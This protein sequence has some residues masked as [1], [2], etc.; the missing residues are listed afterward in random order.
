MS[1]KQQTLNM[2]ANE[3]ADSKSSGM[4]IPDGTIPEEFMPKGAPGN[5]A[6]SNAK[7]MEDLPS[8][9]A[10]I[11][12]EVRAIMPDFDKWRNVFFQ[13]D[14]FFVL[15]AVLLECLL[16]IFLY[17]NNQ[18][19]EP[20]FTYILTNI[21]T[22][23]ILN[24]GILLIAFFIKKRMAPYD[25]RQNYIPIFA[26]LL[27]NIVISVTHYTF[28][29]TLSLFCIP[30]FMT[31]IF[32]AK[33]PCRF[34]TCA[35]IGG[36]LLSTARHF[37]ALSGPVERIEIIPETILIICILII[38]DIVSHTLLGMTEGQKNKLINYA[39]TIGEAHQRA[40]SANVAKSAFLANMS[41][42][43]RTPINAILG[44]NEMILRESDNDQITEYAKNIYSA[45]TSLLYL[46]N[47]VLD[48]S[49]IESG[50]LEIVEA[51]YEISS[52]IH[53]CYNMI[54]EKAAEKNLQLIINCSPQ[55]PSQL[56]GDEVR[57]RQV[58][59]NLLSNAAKYTQEGSVTLSVD[60]RQ[61]KDRFLL[62]VTVKDTGIGIK[63]DNLK[64]LFSQFARFDLEKNRNIEGT[65]LGLAITKQL[66]DL[67][68]GEIH[69]ESTYGSG[70]SFTIIVPQQ[71]IESK[72]MGD[73]FKRY[74]DVSL[75]D[76]KY[77]QSFEAPDARVLVVD[78]VEVNLKVIFNLL[79]KT[80][81]KVDTAL[82]GKQCL[83]LTAENKYDLILLDHMMPEM[84]GIETYTKMKENN[85]SPNIDTPVIML[86]ANAITGVRE[87][88]LQA[89]FTD[90]LSKPVSGTKLEQM[91]LK[92]LPEAKVKLNITEVSEEDTGKPDHMMLLQN[93][94]QLYPQAD[95]VLGLSSCEQSPDIYITTLKTFG[96]NIKSEQL[97][98]C[99]KNEDAETYQILLDEIKNSSRKIG[100]LD[101]TEEADCLKTAA[102]DTDWDYIAGHHQ[103]FMT[104][105]Q[106][107]ADAIA[108]AMQT[109]P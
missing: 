69:V 64:N 63:E 45:S 8:D 56:K 23:F 74:H 90:Y 27:I 78:D 10:Q 59:T 68:H 3:Y 24:T 2:K 36:V 30:I 94:F 89:G 17:Y 97:N 51:T 43:I 70:S 109:L 76:T 77:Q 60:S 53:D 75:N 47:D 108:A 19:S 37:F 104:K 35:S 91:I 107:A 80:K 42:E 13:M 12:K 29:A 31:T 87:Q 83:S 105:Y 46:V 11:P 98:T 92:Y 103:T 49:K 55:L 82:S 6:F 9:A 81:I 66:V 67:M 102:G 95:L 50:K 62:I 85:Q 88:Y 58:I 32:S 26:L 44:M 84:N 73:F 15:S 38:V 16:C 22:P 33:K 14:L 52:F 34:M 40:E 54:Q 106:K 25:L 72:P 7:I 61:E 21:I 100:F 28:K 57:L 18:I 20:L 79:K 65:G 48:F 5:G 39:R 93:L 96:E 86:T 1:K 99:I 41:H 101:L 71:V 4:H